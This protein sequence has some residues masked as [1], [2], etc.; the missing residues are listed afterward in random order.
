MSLT[1][2]GQ[3]LER[4]QSVHGGPILIFVLACTSAASV[5]GNS[6]VWPGVRHYGHDPIV[7]GKS[8]AKLGN[9]WN[10]LSS[11]KCSDRDASLFSSHNHHRTHWLNWPVSDVMEELLRC[12]PMWVSAEI[13][14]QYAHKFKNSTWWIMLN[15]NINLIR[16]T[17]KPT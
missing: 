2:R 11:H 3:T 8:G 16:A 7:G 6:E 4:T 13:N 1:T 14:S 12:S 10:S 5:S 9:K 15:E 17:I